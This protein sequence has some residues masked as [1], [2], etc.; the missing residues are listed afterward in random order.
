MSIHEN[1]RRRKPQQDAH[2]LSTDEARPSVVKGGAATNVESDDPII[3][4]DIDTMLFLSARLAPEDIG[5]LSIQ[6]ARAAGASR[7]SELQRL[8]LA[9]VRHRE[10]GTSR[11]A[12]T[13]DQNVEAAR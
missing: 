5:R 2:S 1:A 3:A 13:S 6:I 10:T 8:L 7:P 12:S 11:T 4:V 9:I